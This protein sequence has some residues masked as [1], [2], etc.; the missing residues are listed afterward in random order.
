[1]LEMK[2]KDRQEGRGEDEPMMPQRHSKG[3]RVAIVGV[4]V[5]DGEVVWML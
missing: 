1:M 5:E 4:G 3:S 2:G